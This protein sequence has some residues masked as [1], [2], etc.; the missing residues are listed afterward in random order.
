MSITAAD[1][2]Y[3]KVIINGGSNYAYKLMDYQWVTVGGVDV[4]YW[5]ALPGSVKTGEFV[6]NGDAESVTL[7]TEKYIAES[8]NSLWKK[9]DRFQH[10]DFLVSKDHTHVFLYTKQGGVEKVW[11]LDGAEATFQSTL[12]NR[13]AEYGTLKK[14]MRGWSGKAATY[15]NMTDVSK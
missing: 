1:L 2:G 10:G 11:R 12:A 7:F 6:P 13:E 5:I 14:L 8:F 3:N 4:R 9:D 15:D